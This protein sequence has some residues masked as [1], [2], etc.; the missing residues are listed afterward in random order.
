MTNPA[1]VEG[2]PGHYIVVMK[3]D[4]L[5]T[6]E[7]DTQNLRRTKPDPGQPLDPVVEQ[8]TLENEGI[9]DLLEGAAGRC[10]ASRMEQIF[11]RRKQK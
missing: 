10:H 1:P 2:T 7:G 4:P 8:R 5:A 6:Y 3:A 9:L 11:D